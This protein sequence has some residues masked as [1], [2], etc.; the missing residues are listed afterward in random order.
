M[1]ATR[2]QV[3][4]YLGMTFWFDKDEVKIDMMEYVENMLDEFPVKFNNHGKVASPAGV[5]L[6]KEDVRVEAGRQG[7]PPSQTSR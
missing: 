1:E 4:D 5:D 2:R 6:F 3:H 7:G